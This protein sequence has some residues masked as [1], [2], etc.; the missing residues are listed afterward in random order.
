VAIIR[1]FFFGFPEF[2]SIIYKETVFDH[3]AGKYISSCKNKTKTLTKKK[4]IA[5]IICN[6]KFSQKKTLLQTGKGCT[7]R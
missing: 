7:C 3:I 2:D 6:G 4:Q 1:L 5:R